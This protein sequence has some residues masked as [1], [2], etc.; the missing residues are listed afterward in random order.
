MHH[1]YKYQ[2]SR[3]RMR[4]TLLGVLSHGTTS[5]FDTVYFTDLTD[6]KVMKWVKDEVEN[7]CERWDWKNEDL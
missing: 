3:G 5:T 6:K 4:Y 7:V 1:T 2:D